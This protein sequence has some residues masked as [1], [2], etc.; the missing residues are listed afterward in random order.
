M[1]RQTAM[2]VEWARE[3]RYLREQ[4]TA[5]GAAGASAEELAALSARW[6]ATFKPEIGPSLYA[7]LLDD[8]LGQVDHN[9]VVAA[10]LA[11]GAPAAGQAAG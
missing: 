10:L 6:M 11:D 4:V 8:A 5:E 2:A 9:A 3:E 1:N 7:T